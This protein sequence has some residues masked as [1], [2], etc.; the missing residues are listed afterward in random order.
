MA[1][2]T[3][4]LQALKRIREAYKEIYQILLDME[5]RTQTKMREEAAMWKQAA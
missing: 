1:V 3:P 2:D 4:T 5:A